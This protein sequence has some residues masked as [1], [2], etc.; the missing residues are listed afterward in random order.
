MAHE[1]HC[2]HCGCRLHVTHDGV[3]VP[4]SDSVE[5]LRREIAQLQVTVAQL[6]GSGFR[7][8][9][10]APRPESTSA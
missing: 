2:P 6:R 3:K 7:P 5:A 8:R 9:L 4:E 1:F 10:L